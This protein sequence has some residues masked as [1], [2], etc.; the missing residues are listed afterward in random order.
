MFKRKCK[1]PFF[2]NTVNIKARVTVGVV[3][4]HL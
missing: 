3:K 4:I 1:N 2:E